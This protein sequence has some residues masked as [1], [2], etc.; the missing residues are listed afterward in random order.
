MFAKELQVEIEVR[1][2][3]GKGFPEIAKLLVCSREAE[4]R[5]LRGQANELYGTRL[6]FRQ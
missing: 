3:R 4:P 1:A 5:N 6:I 2:W